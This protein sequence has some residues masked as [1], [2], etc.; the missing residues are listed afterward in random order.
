MQQECPNGDSQETGAAGSGVRP[1]S[2][3]A[4]DWPPSQWAHGP[5]S[6]SLNGAAWIS[7]MDYPSFTRDND[8]P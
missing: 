5:H 7:V 1:L 3:L 4:Q 2:L 8:F 6:S